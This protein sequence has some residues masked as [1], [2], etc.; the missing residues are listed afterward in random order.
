M[1]GFLFGIAMIPVIVGFLLLVGWLLRVV[2]YFR[3]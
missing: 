3:P 2:G 1:E